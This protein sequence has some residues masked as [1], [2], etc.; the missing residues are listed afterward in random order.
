L[1]NYTLLSHGGTQLFDDWNI[2]GVSYLS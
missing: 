2:A 1:V